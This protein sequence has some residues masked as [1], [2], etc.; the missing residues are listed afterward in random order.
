MV[1][2]P[3]LFCSIDISLEGTTGIV[4]LRTNDGDG[5]T[6]IYDLNGRLLSAPRKGINIINGKKVIINQ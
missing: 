4:Q 1:K 2:V 6:R 3:E 5:T